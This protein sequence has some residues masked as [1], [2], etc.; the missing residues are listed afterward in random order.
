MA[1]QLMSHQTSGSIIISA[2]I[3]SRLAGD[4]ETYALYRVLPGM[5]P[6]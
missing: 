6:N 2:H 5:S 4:N 3:D 1:V